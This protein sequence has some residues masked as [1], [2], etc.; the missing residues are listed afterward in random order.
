MADGTQVVLPSSQYSVTTSIVGVSAVT[1]TLDANGV[2]LNA[3]DADKKGVALVVIDGKDGAVTIS[4]DIVVTAAIPVVTT[5]AL[6]T[7]GPVTITGTVATVTYGNLN[8]ANI[9]AAV[10]AKDQYGIAINAYATPALVSFTNLTKASG[11][12]LL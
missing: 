8:V 4:K 12:Q 9:L 1:N 5:L 10:T 6:A 3:G 7:A 11:S 2:S